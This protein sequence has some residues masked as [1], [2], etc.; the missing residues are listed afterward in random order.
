MLFERKRAFTLVELLVVIA[1]LGILA[2]A[3]TTQVTRATSMGKS[4]RC[5]ANLKNLAQA[6]MSHAVANN[7]SRM[8]WAGSHEGVWPEDVSGTYMPVYHQRKGWVSWTGRT[9]RDWKSQQTQSGS[10][11]P[12][13]FYGDDSASIFSITNGALWDFVGRDMSAYVCDVHQGI[14]K[15]ANLGK[16]RR[17]YV[18]N[19][20]FGYDYRVGS[21]I[22]PPWR[23]IHMQSLA[24]R[25]N[26]G[27]LLLFAELPAYKTSGGKFAEGVD[28][29]QRPSDGVLETVI[30]NYANGANTVVSKEEVIGFNHQVG[31]RFCAHVAYADGHVDVV[32]APSSPSEKK[33]QDL[34]FLLCNGVDV[35]ARDSE[36]AGARS[37]FLGD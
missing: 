22:T 27:G 25:G 4:I 13:C 23:E 20:Y 37:S 17:S 18:M 16:I 21:A 28:K 24:N 11:K 32:I 1:I 35:P 3:L 7:D 8:P 15:R 14:A 2:A 31:K 29:G 34:T 19:A 36:W 9:D 30:K 12:A 5:K 10:T 6:A 33:L 26:A